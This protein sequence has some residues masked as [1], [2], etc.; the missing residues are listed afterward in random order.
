[1]P[2]FLRV[3]DADR[4]EL[5][6]QQVSQKL[7]DQTLLAV[8]HRGRPRG[9]ELLARVLPD[10]VEVVEVAEDVGFGASTGRRAD[11]DATAKALLV[12]ELL[13]DA[14]QAVALVARLD[15]SGDADVVDRRH[16]HEKA[17]GERRV[18]GQA[19]ALGAERLL[20]D[21]DDNLLPF[22]Q[23]L[24]DLRLGCPLA[25]LGAIAML[26]V[27]ARVEAV[28]LLDGIDDVRH[29]E[30]AVALETDVNERALHAGQHF[31]DPAFVDIPDDP[32]M[33]L[34]LDEDLGDEILLEDGDHRL[35][36]VGRDDHFLL[37]SQSSMT[38]RH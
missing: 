12:A 22:L 35:V 5:F 25:A 38:D 32:A 29:V 28:E 4:R 9:L 17:A 3:V 24:F 37:H 14:A 30:E 23:E 26:V 31:R 8:D 10:F 16:E 36:P 6:G 11:D 7:G 20:G 15:F 13:H 2:V 21:L 18:R 27:V 34:P 1:M 33:P 19:R